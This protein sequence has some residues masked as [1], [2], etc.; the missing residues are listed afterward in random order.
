[1]IESDLEGYVFL[2]VNVFSILELQ[3]LEN[4]F[5]KKN[6]SRFD[7]LFFFFWL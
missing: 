3:N 6:Y 4:V 1:M 5:L 2:K 7:L